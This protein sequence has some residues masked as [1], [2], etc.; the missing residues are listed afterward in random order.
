MFTGLVEE[1]GE[2][3]EVREGPFLRVRIAAREVLSDLKV[4]DSVAVDG[5]CLTAVEVDEGGFWVELARE[6]LRRILDVIPENVR[7]SSRSTWL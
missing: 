2:I 4:G 1:T 6:T 5:V 7:P 3:V